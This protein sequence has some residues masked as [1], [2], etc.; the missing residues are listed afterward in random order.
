ML[1]RLI[2]LAV[3]RRIATLVVTVGLALFGVFTLTKL[4]IEAFPD[5]TNVQVMVISLFPGQAAEEVEKQVTIPVERALF[6]VPNVLVQRSIT[7][8]GLSQVVVTFEDGVDIY[9]ARQ[10]E[11]EKLPNAEVHEGITPSL[12]PNDTPVGQVYQYTLESD[13]HSPS[14]LRSWQ[15]WVIERQLMRVPGVADVVSFGGYQKEYHVL[16][17]PSRLR[18]SGV[19]LKE[20]ITAVGRSSGATSGGYVQYGESEFVVRSRAYLS[21]VADIE[22]TVIAAQNGTP[23]LVRNVARV[24]EGYT[25]RRGAV[26]RGDAIDSVEGT[27]LLRRGE[28]PRDVLTEVHHAVDRINHDVLPKGMRIV[29]FYDRTKLVDTTLN[30][31]G[32]NMVEGAALVALV[33]WLFLR[34]LA[35]SFA[36]AITMPLAL[37]SAFAGLHFAGVPANMMSVG[38]IDFGILLDGAVILVEN[39]YQHLADKQPAPAEVPGV[40]AAASKEVVRPILFSLSIIVAAMLP[41]FTLERVEGRI[42]RPVALTYAFALAGALLFTLTTVPALIAVLLRHGKV[43]E[44]EPKF[45]VFLRGHYLVA[46]QRALRSPVLTCSIGVLIL[47]AA[48]ALIP[49]LGT[50]FLPEMNEGDI[51]ITVT[52]PTETSL[53]RGAEVLRETRLALLRYPEVADVLTE[54]GHPEDGTDDEAPNQAETFVMMKPENEW[55]TG[56]S[57]R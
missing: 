55:K 42:F 45:L 28:N 30:T 22:G 39:V 34:A 50:E 47:A 23:I 6:G 48:V 38:A 16:A 54:Q 49:R 20:L 9:F 8:F 32:H 3:Q 5:V 37:L 36:V 1:E 31:A 56:R 46:L 4:K 18:A 41:V 52:M 44:V 11:A 43:E 35:G 7:S 26:A 57:K 15:D 19:T 10:Q 21:G 40:V 14:E 53:E 2:D 17:D 13:H 24:V 51:H 29:T 12:G 27:I 25:P 33:L